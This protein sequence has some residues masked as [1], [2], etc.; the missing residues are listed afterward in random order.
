MLIRL[1]LSAWEDSE[2]VFV[3]RGIQCGE[4]FEAKY[5]VKYHHV[6]ERLGQA[7]SL[8]AV[9]YKEVRI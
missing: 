6:N 4:F 9:L 1:N 2:M 3:S 7:I 8:C 5:G